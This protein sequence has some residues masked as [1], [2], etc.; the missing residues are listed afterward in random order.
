[1]TS[2]GIETGLNFSAFVFM[3][4]QRKPCACKIGHRKFP[5]TGYNHFER[6]IR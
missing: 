3:H 6:D 2:Q 1:M 4:S 5:A